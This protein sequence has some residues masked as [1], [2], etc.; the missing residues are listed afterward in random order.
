MYISENLKFPSVTI[1]APVLQT[2]TFSYMLFDAHEQTGEVW[3]PV[4]GQCSF[5]NRG[6]WAVEVLSQ[7]SW[8][9]YISAG[10]SLINFFLFYY[11]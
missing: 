7:S 5:E 11:L 4:K 3:K 9:G 1:I 8:N 2:L 10:G 6:S